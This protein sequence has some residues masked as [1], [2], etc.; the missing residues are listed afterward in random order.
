MTK[1]DVKNM[2]GENNLKTEKTKERVGYRVKIP[3]ISFEE[4]IRILK[5]VS[6]IGSMTGTF[7][8]LSEVT[9]NSPS[10]SNLNY[11]ISALKNFGLLDVEGRNYT[12]SSI[13]EKIV[14][15]QSPDDEY[16]AIQEA[17]SKHDILNRIWDNYKGKLLPQKEYLANYIEKSHGIPSILKMEWADY[18]I[19]AAKFARLIRE[20]EQGSNSYQVLS[21]PYPPTTQKITITETVKVNDEIQTISVP[22][23][24]PPV[25]QFGTP[26]VLT[27][28]HW[29]ILN[30]K[31]ISGDRKVIF[32]IPDEL[33]QQDIDTL[34][35]ILKGIDA[36]LEGFKKSEP[37]QN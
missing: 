36:S 35:V 10:S 25:Q 30:Q 22:S 34:R 29:G 23:I 9:G 20:R 15:P 5:E 19:E 6:K 4:A 3:F 8:A 13:G 16:Q 37:E 12:I 2:S 14:Q 11:K 1:Q 31:K 26:D 32:A 24:T 21:Q 27:S 17:F 33:T 18:F 7:D 28:S